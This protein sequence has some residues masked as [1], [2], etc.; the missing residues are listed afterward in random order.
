MSLQVEL[1]TEASSSTTIMSADSLAFAPGVTVVINL[2]SS[3]VKF[4]CPL[5]QGTGWQ[6]AVS[7]WPLEFARRRRKLAQ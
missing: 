1:A 4:Y 2:E 6:F 7:G 3:E 5:V